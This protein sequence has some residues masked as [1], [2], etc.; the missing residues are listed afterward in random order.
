[1]WYMGGGGMVYG[2]GRYGV[3]GG[4]VWYMGWGGVLHGGR[5]YIGAEMVGVKLCDCVPCEVRSNSDVW[6]GDSLLLLL[7][8]WL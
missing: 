7:N 2:V 1:M 3:W 8:L 4:A 5:W 6:R